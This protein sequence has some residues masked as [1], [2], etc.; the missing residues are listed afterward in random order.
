M[1]TP[2]A[3]IPG[4][5]PPSSASGPS[6]AGGHAGIV[7]AGGPPASPQALRAWLSGQGLD[8][9]IRLTPHPQGWHLGLPEALASA[10]APQHDTLALA[11]RAGFYVGEGDDALTRETV[12]ALLLG[13][14]A[15]VF[16]SVEELAAHVR[17][18]VNIARAAARTAL[19]FETAAAERPAQYWRYD[20]DHGFLLRPG[21]SLIEALRVTTQPEVSGQLYSFSCYRATEYVILLGIAEELARSNP[22][23]LAS[24]ETC[25]QRKAIMSGR[26]H[27]VFLHEHGSIEAP[28]PPLYYVPGDR[29]WFRNPD[30]AS[31]DASGFEGSWTVY[32]G[33]G[34]FAN[35]WERNRPFSFDDKCL[36]VFHWRDGLHTDAQGEP[37]IDEAIVAREVARTQADPQRREAILARM[38][39]LRDPRG[40]Y[41]EGGCI[42][43]TRESPRWVCPGT[44]D[45]VLPLPQADA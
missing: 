42:D 5:V 33:G 1:Q 36:E 6:A 23:L 30:E 28:L 2:A 3:A 26:F 15:L 24:L 10:W 41:A 7:V 8:A 19:A 22:P 34:L 13:A 31:A 39:R 40:V 16:P 32:L 44:A 35:F 9:V 17:M 11:A 4:D 37:R 25:W 29:V 38:R 14:Q 20:E 21:Q 12:L 27:D 43:A 45:L 18:R